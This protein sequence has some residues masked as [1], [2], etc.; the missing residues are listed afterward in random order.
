MDNYL[1][2][3]ISFFH[4]FGVVLVLYIH[5]GMSNFGDVLIYHDFQRIMTNAVCRVFQPLYFGLAGYLFFQN[6]DHC[7]W[8]YAGKIKKR[9]FSQFVP[10]VFFNTL[11]G[12]LIPVFHQVSFLN[13]PWFVNACDYFSNHNIFL[14]WFYRPA[15]GQ[16]WFVRDLMICVV[17]TGPLYFLI[18]KTKGLFLF[19]LLPF[20]VKDIFMSYSL[21][22]FGIG[23][24]FAIQRID[25]QKIE[26][27]IKNFLMILICLGYIVVY[28]IIIKTF[29]NSV[30][31]FAWALFYLLWVGYDKMPVIRMLQDKKIF[32]FCATY[33]FFTYLM[34]DPLMS[35]LKFNLKNLYYGSDFFCFVVYFL[36][37]PFV[38]S[39]CIGLGLVIHK[40][41]PTFYKFIAGGR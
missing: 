37:P 32:K 15:L 11:W 26:S 24:F 19:L 3:K 16:L 36:L 1:S 2:K 22:S 17:F 30:F 41:A 38:Y 8:F 14:S 23:A 12:V 9:F 28:G 4:F 21:L 5:A 25:V 27:R 34:H 33:G 6:I 29:D 39:V 35:I 20:C 13:T 10:Y 18:K 7:K 40:I 31:L